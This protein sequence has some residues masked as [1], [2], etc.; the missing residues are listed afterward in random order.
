MI[1]APRFR[2]ID[3]LWLAL[4]RLALVPVVLV[5]ERLVDHPVVHTAT[6]PFWLVAFGAW[7]AAVLALRLQVAPFPVWLGR[8]EPFVDLAFITA[9]DVRVRRPVLRDRDGLLRA[10]R[11][12]VASGCGRG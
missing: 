10:P 9:L 8:A 4:L 1:D 3:Q 11:A 2:A 7:A 12:R 5:G 6:F